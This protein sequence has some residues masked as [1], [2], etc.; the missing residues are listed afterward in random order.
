MDVHNPEHVSRLVKAIERSRDDL[1][2]FRQQHTQILGLLNSQRYGNSADYSRLI[3]YLKMVHSVLLRSLVSS[4]PRCLITTKVPPLRPIAKAMTLA[5]NHRAKEMDLAGT[6]RAVVAAALVSIGFMKTGVCHHKREGTD[7]LLHDYMQPYVDPISLAD[8]FHDT[9]AKRIDH[10]GFCGHTYRLPKDLLMQDPRFNPE[11][12]EGIETADKGLRDEF[13]NDNPLALS[14]RRDHST[15]YEDMVN[16]AE[17]W[18]PRENVVMTF[19]CKRA[20]GI[21]NDDPLLIEEYVGPELG[22]YLLLRF[23]ELPD[24]IMPCPPCMDLADIHVAKQAVY[25]KMV[26]DQLAEKTVL[27]NLNGSE[28]D[29]ASII[30]APNRGAVNITGSAPPTEVR[31]GGMSQTALA[32]FARLCMDGNTWAGNLAALAGT[33]PSADTATQE[34]LLTASASKQIEG[35]QELTQELVY[36]VMYN[37][38]WYWW[39]D[40]Q[41]YNVEVPV[42]GA[43]GLTVPTTITAEE[44]EGNWL[45]M[46]FELVPYSH[47]VKSPG[48]QLQT[49]RSIWQ[50]DILPA[51]PFMQQAGIAPNLQGYLKVVGELEGTP[52]LDDL[53]MAQQPLAAEEELQEPPRYQ[54]QN[55]TT[56]RVNRT[57]ATQQGQ[58]QAQMMAAMGA[59]S[60]Q[61][62]GAMGRPP[63]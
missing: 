5:C 45:E 36:R 46:N 44:R 3:P 12:V 27:V 6:L 13:G 34:K 16:L 61:Q 39:R 20:G 4:N 10:F 43:P 52:Y 53:V 33:S 59:A 58:E 21:L 31:Y 11:Q 41:N 15:D 55:K 26:Q 40:G 29:M 18:L 7:G 25:R 49:V 14:N 22:P 24:N 30:N 17:V 8:W 32:F 35:M 28:G 42:D 54:P 56:T 62:M 23:G 2:P 19:A 48:Q 9:S 63:Q 50:Q 57:G 51:M 47:Q 60:E 1:E 37:T 38:C